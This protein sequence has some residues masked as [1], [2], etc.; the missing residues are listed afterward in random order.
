MSF[1]MHERSELSHI[2]IVVDC[3]SLRFRSSRTV[4]TLVSMVKMSTSCQVIYDF[5]CAP[6]YYTATT[7]TKTTYLDPHQKR[8]FIVQ[9]FWGFEKVKLVSE[10][11][12][13]KIKRKSGQ[14]VRIPVQKFFKSKVPTRVKMEKVTA[15]APESE[16]HLQSVS[17]LQL[18]LMQQH[19][20]TFAF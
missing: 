6:N 19:I 12:F 4:W 11:F 5:T 17:L 16:S 10:C 20:C 14:C 8:K 9:Q 2:Y 15:E 3:L 18:S 1:S 13:L 7:Y